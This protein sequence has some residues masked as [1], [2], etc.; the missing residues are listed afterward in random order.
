[1]D[2]SFLALA[3]A[4]VLSASGQNGSPAEIAA[5]VES[6]SQAAFRY[7][8]AI[9]GLLQLKPGMTAAE[10]GTVSGFV[11]RAMATQVG[12][13]GRVIATTL[14][15]GMVPY[16]TDRARSEGLT[17]FTAVVA[18]PGATGLEPASTDA[19]ALVGVFGAVEQRKEMLQALG[20]AL[21]PGGAL[22]IVDLPAENDGKKVVGIE[23]EDVV[24]L[25]VEAGFKRE[26]ESG[27]VPGHYAIRF[28][29]P[30]LPPV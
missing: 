14:N 25:A 23:A 4:C 13:T 3:L 12:P 7:R 5:R 21:K 9:A 28:R 8:V 20:G 11:A 10:V 18:K 27:I 19:I 22:L 30:L 17:T 15:P 29:K 1:M 2:R 6:P 26:A 24:K 16:M